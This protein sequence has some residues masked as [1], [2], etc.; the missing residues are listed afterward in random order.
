M[1]RAALSEHFLVAPSAVGGSPTLGSGRSVA[2]YEPGTTVPIAQTMYASVDGGVVLPQPLQT[3]AGGTVKA[4]VELPQRCSLLVAGV[5]TPYD[6]EFRVDPLSLGIAAGGTAKFDGKQSQIGSVTNGSNIITVP[7]GTEHNGFTAADVGKRMTVIQYTLLATGATVETNVGN[8]TIVSVLDATRVT[9]S[10]AA[11]ATIPYNP[12]LSPGTFPNGARVIWGTDDTAALQSLLDTVQDTMADPSGA[13]V[14]L[15]P[16]IALVS[17]VLM[18]NNRHG[19][20][21]VGAGGS[22][23]RFGTWR[24]TTIAGVGPGQSILSV[25]GEQLELSGLALDGAGKLAAVGLDLSNDAL[26]YSNVRQ[27][28]VLG[29]VTG[30]KSAH[31]QYSNAFNDVTVMRNTTGIDFATI[32]NLAIQKVN[33][34]NVAAEQNS[35]TGIRLSG[36]ELV[37][38]FGGTSQINARGVQIV[39]QATSSHF[40]GMHYEG[41]AV[42][43]VD[44]RKDAPTSG[45][46]ASVLA[47][48]N[49]CRF[50]GS[51]A[52][53][54][55]KAV[56]SDG[57]LSGTFNHCYFDQFPSGSGSILDFANGGSGAGIA[58]N[59]G[60]VVSAD[61]RFQDNGCP[62]F[63]NQNGVA[64]GY[65]MGATVTQSGAQTIAS[66]LAG[67]VIN[68]NLPV[69]DPNYMIPVGGGS[70]QAPFDGN[71]LVQG[72]IRLAGAAGGT[73]RQGAIFRN[74]TAVALAEL[75][76]LAGTPSDFVLSVMLPCVA[77]DSFTLWALQNS[78]SPLAVVQNATAPRLS[79]TRMP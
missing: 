4:W 59:F 66:D 37:N 62:V 49:G 43:A 72:A 56:I 54:T 32:A 68:L 76:P 36:T 29:C 57:S 51:G 46:Y 44:I 25:D 50:Y 1:S 27:V 71:Y 47:S 35:G 15:P 18:F 39:G 31:E 3:D 5:P 70:I 24:G 26:H 53:F 67:H 69:Y 73:T 20:R 28:R 9:L 30:I 79:V 48:W 21:I 33:F 23:D 17:S 74:G 11:S 42:A 41:N 12:A 8:G 58:L 64:I 52:G 14:R 45:N 75:P 77:G 6:A 34:Y 2:V 78:G 61:C 63:G 16:G 60:N 19:A 22:D 7:I 55:G 10:V 13:E 40:Y 38:F 65:A